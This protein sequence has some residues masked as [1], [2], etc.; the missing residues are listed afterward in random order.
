M[1]KENT[2]RKILNLMDKKSQIE[3]EI[4]RV[5]IEYMEEK[6]GDTIITL[7]IPYKKWIR[8]ELGIVI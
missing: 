3:E 7:S 4:K 1:N 2:K 8:E 5:M 6:T